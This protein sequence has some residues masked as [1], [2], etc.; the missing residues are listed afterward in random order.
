M[1]AVL[2]SIGS[3]VSASII[4]RGLGFI[5][6]FWLARLLGPSDYGAWI[7]ILLLSAYAPILTL[8]T[9][10]TLRKRVPFFNG[11]GELEKAQ[12]IEKNVFTF[13]LLV[14]LLFAVLTPFI[15]LILIPRGLGRYGLPTRLMLLAVS[16]SMLSS[17]YY[18]RLEAYSRFGSISAIALARSVLTLSL[19][20]AF[21]SFMGLTGAV[22][23]Y[24]ISEIVI[25]VYSVFAG[26]KLPTRLGLRIDFPAFRM[27][28]RMGLPITIIWWT[29]MIQTTV[30]RLVSMAMLG[31]AATGYY[32]IG[33]SITTAYLLLPD[34]INQVLYPRVNEKYGQTQKAE[35]LVPLVVDP[36]KIMSLIL[37]FLSCGFVLCMP[38]VFLFVVPQ[39]MPGLL[40][41]Q[42]LIVGALFSGLTRGGINLLISIDRQ[43][44]VLA[45]ILGSVILN[46]AGNILLVKLGLGI[47]GIALST[48]FSS[49][50]LA[51][52]I[53]YLVFQSIG[54]SIR[55][56]ISSTA[57]LFLPALIFTFLAV[58]S[59]VLQNVTST[60]NIFL[61]L[62][63]IAAQL[64]I[65]CGIIFAVSRYRKTVLGAFVYI[66]GVVKERLGGGRSSSGP[67][68]AAGTIL[69]DGVVE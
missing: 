52:S 64:A 38:L 37:P 26:K 29:F 7:F 40:A 55:K 33:M 5:R 65:Y 67:G 31:E 18:Y 61:S 28:V 44:T 14:C 56:R 3:F 63:F 68:G 35:D 69:G 21:G 15:P 47:G 59:R 62:I 1:T 45:L 32:G 17:F 49:G 36:A 24:L 2:M 8:G 42:I 27:L 22:L 10:E 58:V 12:E 23:G 4:A 41:A 43:R 53:W 54:F 48:A 30:D 51:L 46:V 13:V 34:A 57:E 60:S 39:Y 66:A 19:Q 25:C 50:C 9:V 16:L 6:S 11:K 20:I